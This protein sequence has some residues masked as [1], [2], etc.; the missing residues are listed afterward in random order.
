MLKIFL[1]ATS[2]GILS[3]VIG[4]GALRHIPIG[5]DAVSAR[6][7]KAVSGAGGCG[8][9]YISF[10]YDCGD[11]NLLCCDGLGGCATQDCCSGTAPEDQPGICGTDTSKAGDLIYTG[12]VG[13]ISCLVCGGQCCNIPDE[14]TFQYCSGYGS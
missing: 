6:E 10:D 2:I 9:P 13:M 8:N 1:V 5:A 4:A 7:A 12:N 11:V 3:M 14:P